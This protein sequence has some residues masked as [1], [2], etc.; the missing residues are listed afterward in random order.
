MNSRLTIILPLK[1][2]HPFTLRF[3]WHANKARLPYRFLIA[4]GEVHPELA[5]ILDDSRKTLPELDL[6]YIRY[7][8]DVD[9]QHYFVKMADALQRVRTPYAML[10]D[11]D[12]FPMFAGIERSLD[13]LESHPDYVCCGG[14]IGGFSVYSGRQPSLAGLLGPLNRIAYRYM[15]YDRS[16]DLGAPSVTDRLL[17]GLRNSWSYYAVYRSPALQT[18]WRE[19]AEI[20]LSDLQLHEKFCAMRTL[21]FGKARSDAATIGYLRQ[22]WT[23][24]RSA[25]AKDWVHHLLRNRFSTDF[26]NIIDRISGLAAAADGLDKSVVAE[27]LREHIAPWL[28]DFLR[29]N[30]G[31]SGVTRQYVRT[32]APAVLTWL[33]MRRRYS[34]PVERLAVFAKLRKNGASE[35][36]I[37]AFAA[38]LAQIED[39]IAGNAFRDFILPLM[40]TF[41]P[42]SPKK[43]FGGSAAHFDSLGQRQ[44]V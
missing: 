36:Y 32:A 27:N 10:A 30:Y 24:M 21:T 34:V 12:D 9:F 38:E 20:N 3:L 33:K 16:I 25:F 5:K 28:R 41:A 43:V 31:L 18:I 11:N 35:D 22:Y 14:G 40:R 8:D 6:E 2:R 19:V 26:A 44:N 15:P 13:F 1:G 17:H 42:D 4:D 29:L 7:P 39:V 37:K 23:S